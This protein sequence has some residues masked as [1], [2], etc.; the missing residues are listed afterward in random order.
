MTA[1]TDLN[2]ISLTATAKAAAS[3]RGLDIGAIVALAKTHVIELSRLLTVIQSVHPSSG[4]D[5]ANYA[6]LGTIIGE[7]A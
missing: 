5:A 3:A 4:G 2:A 1:L 7:L 6:A